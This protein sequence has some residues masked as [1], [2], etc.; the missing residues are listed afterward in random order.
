MGVAAALAVEGHGRRVSY[1]RKVFIPLTQLCRDVCHYCTFAGPPR[2]GAAAY[3]TPAQVLGIARAGAASGCQEALFTLGDKPELR[4]RQAREELARPRLRQHAGLSRALRAP[5]VRGN[6]PAAAPEPRRDDA[7]RPRA[8]ASVRGVDGADARERRRP[9]RA[10]GRAAPSLARQA[11]RAAPRDAARGGRTRHPVHDGPADRHR[12]DASRAPRGAARDPRP[13]P[14]VR[15][16]PGPHHPELPR[17]ARHA[18]G[19][20]AR[21]GARGTALDDR[22]RAPAVRRDDVDPGAAEPQCA[23]SRCRDCWPPA[24][25]TGAASR[26]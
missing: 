15:A 4:Y 16:R 17:Q 18:H 2:R 13:A 7:R 11:P 22:R 6:R 24:S 20:R 19:T 23:R 12:R 1:S 3:L 8:A 14:R 5:R 10:E 25:T 21:T 26:R 9:A